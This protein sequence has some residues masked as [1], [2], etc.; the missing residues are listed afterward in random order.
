MT[1]DELYEEWLE[2]MLCRLGIERDEWDHF[3]HCL[4]MIDAREYSARGA[5]DPLSPPPRSQPAWAYHEPD[6]IKAMISYRQSLSDSNDEPYDWVH[7][8]DGEDDFPWYTSE[9][10]EP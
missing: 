5:F 4:R 9:D 2:A 1:P 10:L 7:C 6:M 8:N 3:D